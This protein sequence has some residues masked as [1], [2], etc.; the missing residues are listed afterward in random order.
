MGFDI[1]F[2]NKPIIK[3]AQNTQDG[4][5]GNLGYF[6][7]QKNSENEDAD[8]SVFLEPEDDSDKFEKHYDDCIENDDDF[9][10]AKLIAKII[11]V[12][13]DLLKKVFKV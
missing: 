1:N 4:G 11:L 7:R 2:N 5:A 9:S 8:K 3:G 10:I 6:K 13:K 12:I